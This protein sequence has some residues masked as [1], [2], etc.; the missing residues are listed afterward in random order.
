MIDRKKKHEDMQWFEKKYGIKIMCQPSSAQAP[1]EED[2]LS[3][4]NVTD[5][6]GQD[7]QS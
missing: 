5:S 3:D 7:D 1:V 6:S 4:D 2:K